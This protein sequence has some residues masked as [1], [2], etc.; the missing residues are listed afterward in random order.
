MQTET[1]ACFLMQGQACLLRRARTSHCATPLHADGVPYAYF[2]LRGEACWLPRARTSLFF[3]RNTLESCVIASSGEG[4]PLSFCMLAY[5]SEGK[6][7][8]MRDSPK[9]CVVAS[10][11]EGKPL[12]FCM[13]ASMVESEPFPA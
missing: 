10:S 9:V 1:D 2:L 5:S 4:E 6:P 7:F 12:S 13:L 3:L 8:F 11:V